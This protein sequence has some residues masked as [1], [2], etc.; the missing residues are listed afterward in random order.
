MASRPGL[1]VSAIRRAERGRN[2]TLATAERVAAAF[3][4]SLPEMLAPEAT[5]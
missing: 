1:N 2:T 4:K 3:G 5:G